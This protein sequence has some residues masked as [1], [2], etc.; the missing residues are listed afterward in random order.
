MYKSKIKEKFRYLKDQTQPF[1]EAKEYCILCDLP[2]DKVLI[3]DPD[4][5]LLYDLYKNKL[6]NPQERLELRETVFV[7]AKKDKYKYEHNLYGTYQIKGISEDGKLLLMEVDPE[8]YIPIVS[9]MD[10]I[11]IIYPSRVKVD[12]IV[13]DV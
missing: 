9:K 1:F 13:E 6:E 2:G 11:K 3:Y 5:E 8:D 4:I 12:V 7:V 10:E